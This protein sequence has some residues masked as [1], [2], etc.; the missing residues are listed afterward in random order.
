VLPKTP[1]PKCK[2]TICVAFDDHTFGK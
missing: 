2:L 1:L